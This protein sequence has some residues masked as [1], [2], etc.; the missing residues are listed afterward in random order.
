MPLSAIDRRDAEYNCLMA[1]TPV[2][3]EDGSTMLIEQI[4]RRRLPVRV[5]SCTDDGRMCSRPVVDWHKKRVHG[6]PWI[7]IRTA[8]MHAK[9]RGLILTPDHRVFTDVGELA[10]CEIVPGMMIRVP[11]TALGEAA[12]TT[13]TTVEPYTV[14]GDDPGSRLRAETRFCITV[15][16]THRFFT[17]FGLVRNCRDVLSMCRMYPYLVDA[18]E[19]TN[20][21]NVYDID[22][23]MADLALQMTRIGLPVD[24]EMRQAIGDRLRALRDEA[25]EAMRPYT[26]GDNCEAFMD[27]VSQ[28]FAAKARAGEPVAGSVRLGPTRAAEALAELQAQRAEWKAYRKALAPESLDE[29]ADTDITLGELDSAIKTA[30]LDLKAAQFDADAFAGLVHTHESAFAQRIAI[31]R[32]DFELARGKRGV[33]FGAKVQQAAILRVAGVPLIKT[34]GKSGL[35]QIDKEVLKG[36][37]RHPAAKALLRYILTD[38]TINVYIE[39]EKRAGKSGSKT[40]PVMVTDDGY[41]H[42]LWAVHKI[43]GRWGSSP[44]VQNFSKRAGGGEE[45]LRAMICAPEGYTFVGAD[46]K[47]LEARLVGAMSQCKYLLDVF[48]RGEDVHAAFAAVGFPDVWPRLNATH[49]EHKK[50]V[51][52]G[53]KCACPT[54]AERDKVRDLTKRLEYGTI[55]GGQ[56]KA[57]WEALVGD[58]PSL[59]QQQVRVFI[60]SASRMM[61]EMVMWREQVLQEAIKSGEIRS[62]ILGRRQVFP[63]WR[64]DPTVAYNFK[65]QS[66]GADL[67]ALGAID[68]GSLYD[69][70]NQVDVRLIHNGHDSVLV[71]CRVELAKQVERDVCEC[72]SREWAGVPFE[73]ESKIA[74]RWSAT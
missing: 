40:R 47:Q 26:E 30:K 16:G 72:W 25:I 1:G 9:H 41:L 60:M 58:F 2:V 66:G 37:E 31:R 23:Q 57:I 20:T 11:E 15:A 51:A 73:M 33:N 18:L 29:I 14:Q 43:T 12:W 63:L 71:L 4:V 42:P 19:R 69:Q 5:L 56:D 53:T 36:F 38:K 28:F 22:E 68:F 65:A 64:V 34:T 62:P 39:G 8:A 52:K 70:T 27:W 10:A 48:K 55:Y 67:W 54:C 50:A 17:S 44:N 49:L 6:Q 24:S 74:T 61:P 13:V 46:Q 3:L 35:P 21:A 45:N 7:C 32:A 59:T